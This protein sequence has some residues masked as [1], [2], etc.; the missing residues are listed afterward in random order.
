MCIDHRELNK[1]TAKNRYQLPRIDNIF[2]QLQGSSVYSKINLRER[3]S[4][5]NI[6]E[7][8]KKEEMYPKFSMCNFWLSKVQFLG[9]VINSEGSG[10]F[11]IYCD[12]S[13]KGFGAV[14]A[15]KEENYGTED[16]YGMTKKLEPRADGTLCLKNRSWIPCFGDLRALIMHEYLKSKYLI[17]PRPDKMYQ[18]LKKLYWW[19]NMKVEIA[20]YINK[21][22]TC[23]KKAIGPQ[24]D[25]NTA[26]HPQTFGQSERTI[27]ILKDMLHAYVIDFKKGWDRNL[28]LVEVGDTQLTGLDIFHE[29]TKNIIQIKNRI[30]ATCDRQK[31]YTDRRRKALEFQVVD[32]VDKRLDLSISNYPAYSSSTCLQG[33]LV[34]GDRTKLNLCRTIEGNSQSDY[35]L[36]D[37]LMLNV[38][39]RR[40]VTLG[41]LISSIVALTPCG[42]AVRALHLKWREKVT[43]IEELKD[44]SSLALDE[45]IS[46]LKVHEV[47]MEKDSEIYRGKKERVKSIALKAKKKSSDD[48]T[49]TSRSDD[50]EYSMAIRNFKSDNASSL[51]ND[52]MQ[53]EYD[54]LC[55]ISLKIINKNKNLK[56][57]RDLLEKGVLELNKKIK[58]LKR[59]K[60]I[61]I[62]C[63]LCQELKLENAKLKETQ[64]KFVKSDKS[65]NLLKEMVNNQNLSSCKTGLGFDST[66]ALTSRTKLMGF[67]GSSVEKAT[68][69]STIKAHG[70]TILRYVNRMSGKKLTE[71]FFS[72]PMCFILN[73]VITRKKPIHNRIDE[74]KKPSLKPSLKSGIDEWIKDSGCSKHMTG[75]KSLFST[76]KA[77]DGEDVDN[78]AFNLLSVGQIYDNKCQVLLTEDG[79]EILKDV[80]INNEEDESI[81]VDEV[82][83]IKV[84]KNHSLDQIIVVNVFSPDHVHDLP[85]VKP[86]QLV[87]ALVDENDEPEK[88]KEFKDEE[89]FEEEETQEEKEDMEVD[90]KKEENEPELIFLYVEDMVEPEDETVLNSVHEV[91]QSSTTTFLREDGDSLLPSFMR[92]NIN[93]LFGE[94]EVV[95]EDII[96]E[97]GNA[98]ERVECKK[99]KKELEE[100]RIM[101]PKSRPLTQVSIERMITQRVN[102]ALT[103]DRARRVNVS[104]A[105]GS[106]QGEAPTTRE[107]TFSGFMKCNPT[108]FHCVD[109]AVELQRWFEK[110][111]MVLEI[112]KCAEGKKVKFTAATLQGPA[113][114]WW[115]KRVLSSRRSSKDGAR[116]ME[117]KENVK[118]NAYLRGLSENIKGNKRKWENFQSGNSSRENYK[119]NSHHQQNNQK[120]GN[121][122]AMITCH[123]CGKIGHKSWYCKEKNVAI[124]GKC[125]A[126]LDLF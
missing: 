90:I 50:K 52:T 30:Q 85:K 66:K 57:K 94:K 56:T 25:M 20:T 82:V 28:P 6:L 112:S 69:G 68:D 103:A 72:P 42:G 7:L 27:Q 92:R 74:A 95:L 37:L 40:G 13:H 10:N 59:S 29:T 125:S 22:L 51:D 108:V 109:G 76:Y 101:P 24:L 58:K 96:K 87:P 49:S 55:E 77:Y 23:A 43:A 83:N 2:D 67:V 111:E 89:E 91:G 38:I 14:K 33:L 97:F 99:L 104:G 47:V 115:N 48:E 70:S 62:A 11:M 64:V 34:V 79:S 45:L 93:S 120:Q 60:E 18:N 102:E 113:L 12:A 121:A 80:N 54:N 41:S 3:K 26:Y 106:R 5:K 98:E 110:T 126:R 71:H 75:N 124:G 44:L 107:C 73:F 100:V 122:Q 116:V 119:D 78:L 46:N 118:V 4:M 31:S 9:H 1:L 81:E 53:A 61:D 123:N 63:K 32:K 15:R 35:S 88:E 84:S 16:L 21:C 117:S 19:P 17:H 114:T 105:G 86:N 36:S 8:I 39:L 65:A